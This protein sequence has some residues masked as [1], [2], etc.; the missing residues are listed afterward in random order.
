M[1]ELVEASTQVAVGGAGLFGAPH[2]VL[3][4]HAIARSGRRGL[5]LLHVALPSGAEVLPLFSSPE[6]ARRFL[7]SEDPGEAWYA[8]ECY[9]GEM[10]SL[11]LGLYAG[12]DGVLIDPAHEELVDG[13]VPESFVHWE[14]F[15]G[16]LLGDGRAALGQRTPSGVACAGNP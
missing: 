14:S 13:Y 6:A 1:A 16:Y 5:E 8:R 4:H 3:R 12:V 2:P 15:V 9:A 10:V 7:A 11:L